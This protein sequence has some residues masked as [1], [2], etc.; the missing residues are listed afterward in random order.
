[1]SKK[2][3]SALLKTES[4]EVEVRTLWLCMGQLSSAA[5]EKEKESEIAI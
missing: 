4:G 1:M 5:T 3:E 2:L